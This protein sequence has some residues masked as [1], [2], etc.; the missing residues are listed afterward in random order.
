ML[1]QVVIVG[2]I[3]EFIKINNDCRIKVAVQRPFKNEEGEYE[4][5]LVPVY[6]TD[7]LSKNIMEYCTEES[8]IG[9]KGRIKM[10]DGNIEIFA[11]KV[12]FLS[13]KKEDEEKQNEAE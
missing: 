9:V 2:R 5:D 8:V 13:S 3:R 6:A 10:I 4:V 7:S 1:N 12:T 11:E